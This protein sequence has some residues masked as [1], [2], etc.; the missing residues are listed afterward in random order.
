MVFVTDKNVN[1]IPKRSLVE[2]SSPSV[3]GIA[4]FFYRF[5]RFLHMFM[6]TSNAYYSNETFPSNG[7]FKGLIRKGL[8]PGKAGIGE[9]DSG[10][11]LECFHLQIS[12][13]FGISGH[14]ISPLVRSVTAALMVT[15]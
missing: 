10:K 14:C 5:P 13:Y 1:K 11:A 6:S 12:I 15:I 9:E 2:L 8:H 3:S 4:S 7:V